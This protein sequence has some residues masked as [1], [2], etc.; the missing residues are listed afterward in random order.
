MNDQDVFEDPFGDSDSELP[1][2]L[3]EERPGSGQAALYNLITIVFLVLSGLMCAA[4][5]GLF[6]NPNLPY[7]LFP[8]DGGAGAQPTPFIIPTLVPSLTPTEGLPPTWT[9]SAVPTAIGATAGPT[10]ENTSSLPEGLPTVAPTSEVVTP[11]GGDTTPAPV[12]TAPPGQPTV[13]A[14]P[15]TLQEG[16]PA[17]TQN[18]DENGGCAALYLVGQVFGLDDQP[19]DGLAVWVTGENFETPDIT[20]FNARYGAGSYAILLNNAPIEAEFEIQ[21]FTVQ[22]QPL[23]DKHVVRTRATCE[24]NLIFVNFVQN[25]EF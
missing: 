9:P 19:V 23:S 24:E 2:T 11:I 14:F 8:P 21:L 13:S 6:I 1:A 20:K 15:F 7:N 22:A 3:E 18:P 5:A 12:P 17:F 10:V 25:H 16:V 4:V